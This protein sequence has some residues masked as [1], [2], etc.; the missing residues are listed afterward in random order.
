MWLP[1]IIPP[2]TC[3]SVSANFLVTYL[4]LLLSRAVVECPRG[5]LQIANG[6]TGLETK[7]GEWAQLDADTRLGFGTAVI[8]KCDRGYGLPEGVWNRTCGLNGTW[9][10]AT[11]T[12][13]SE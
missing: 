12:C 3:L 13:N 7:E 8:F 9:S 11:P 4:L 5:P 10:G 6:D 2:I 1:Q